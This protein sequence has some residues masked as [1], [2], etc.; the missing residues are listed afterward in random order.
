MNSLE[1][2]YLA[3]SRPSMTHVPFLF[4]SLSEMRGHVPPLSVQL[5]FKQ[6]LMKLVDS[7]F[8]R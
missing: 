1:Q 2:V 7:D 8:E 6:S 4:Q 3:V 5:V